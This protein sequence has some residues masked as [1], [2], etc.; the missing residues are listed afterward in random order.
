MKRRDVLKLAGAAGLAPLI[1]GC[2][3]GGPGTIDTFVLLMMENRSYDHEFGARSFVDGHGGDGLRGNETNPDTGG[4][5]VAL[6][7]G[8]DGN[9]CVPDPAHGW[10]A[11]HTQFNA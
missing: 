7:K 8:A 6:W 5:P 4:N 3:D 10:D 9:L 2:S 1:P 11:S